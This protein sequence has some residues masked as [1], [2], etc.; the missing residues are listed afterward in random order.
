M[1]CDFVGPGFPP[2]I[3]FF[4]SFQREMCRRAEADSAACMQIRD[5]TKRWAT[6]FF[7]LFSP[8]FFFFFLKCCIICLSKENSQR[9]SMYLIFL[10][11]GLSFIPFCLREGQK[12]RDVSLR[13]QLLHNGRLYFVTS[14]NRISHILSV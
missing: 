4:Y 12:G 6:D 13:Q 8:L 3:F 1:R 7:S 10:A 9:H 5:E 14:S 11:I 2:S